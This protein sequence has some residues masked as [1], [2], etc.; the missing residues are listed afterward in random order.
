MFKEVRLYMGGY[1]TMPDQAMS[2][3]GMQSYEMT[4]NALNMNND[5]VGLNEGVM[6]S[7]IVSNKL[8]TTQQLEGYEAND[9]SNY[10]LAFYHMR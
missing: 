9:V 5:A 2:S 8:R 3:Y 1:G 7:M 6:R 10:V 4:Q